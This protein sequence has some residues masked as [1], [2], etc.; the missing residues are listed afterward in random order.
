MSDRYREYGRK[1]AEETKRA[2]LGPLQ[3]PRD[4]DLDAILDS[5]PVPPTQAESYD[6][7]TG[8][9]YREHGRKVAH[10]ILTAMGDGRINHP[11]DLIR[12]ECEERGW[13]HERLAREMGGDVELQKLALDFYDAAPIPAMRLGESGIAGLARAFG[14][15]EEFWRNYERSWLESINRVADS[16]PVPPGTTTPDVQARSAQEG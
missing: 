16:V 10:E 8:D 6:A 15:S 3:N 2:M 4:L 7:P 13:D 1:V 12:E 14:T 11:R 9:G 5:I